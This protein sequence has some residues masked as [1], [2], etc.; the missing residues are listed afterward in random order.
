M[1]F[2]VFPY[3][4]HAVSPKMFDPFI[5]LCKVTKEQNIFN[6]IKFSLFFILFEGRIYTKKLLNHFLAATVLSRTNLF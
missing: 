6:N 4:G 2:V 5:V 1:N 3:I